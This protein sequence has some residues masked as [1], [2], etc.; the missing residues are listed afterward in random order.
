MVDRS[1]RWNERKIKA[2]MYIRTRRTYNM[3]LR[4]SLCPV[5]DSLI[6]YLEE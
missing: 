1:N 5:W 6:R 2:S 4:S 3:N